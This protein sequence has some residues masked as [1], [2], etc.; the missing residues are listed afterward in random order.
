[1]VVA[2]LS[3]SPPSVSLTRHGVIDMRLDAEGPQNRG[4]H[5]SERARMLAGE[6]YRASDPELTSAL[7]PACGPFL[8]YEWS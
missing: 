8:Q 4:T 1:M 6:L 3:V 7:V 5:D 2:G